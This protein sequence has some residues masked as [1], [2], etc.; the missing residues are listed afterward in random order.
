VLD[1]K[2]VTPADARHALRQSTDDLAH[3]F[4]AA[5]SSGRARVMGQPRRAVNM[6]MYLVQHDAHHRG[7]ICT[8]ARSLGHE[9]SGDDTMRLWGWKA[10]PSPPDPIGRARR[11]PKV[12][13]KS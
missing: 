7:Q 4:E 10:I 13:G 6:L 12:P 2:L 11:S 8:L 9:F 3:L 1:R 5:F